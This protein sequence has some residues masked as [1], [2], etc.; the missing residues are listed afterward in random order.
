MKK[1][2]LLPEEISRKIAAGEVIERPRSVVKEL[3]ENSLD[4][5]ASEIKVEL[6]D[7]GKKL[8][9]VTDNGLGMSRKDTL[10]C[11][12]RHS[13]S[14]ISLE[15]DLEEIS[16][17]GF[18]G[19]ALPSISSVS[20]VVLKTA[21]PDDKV[22]ICI[23]REGE[24]VLE[25]IDIA[26]PGGTC[27]EVRDLFFNLPA[28]RKFLRSDRSE[29]SHVVRY[30]TETSLAFPQVGFSLIHGKRQVFSYPAVKSLKERIF[31]IYGRNVLE[32]L[33]AVE[34]SDNGRNITGFLS[35]PPSGRR[36]RG[37][38]F[39]FINS[40]PVRD[41]SLQAALNQAY[42]GFLEKDLSPA[43]F[44]FLKIPYEEVDINVHPAKT[45]VRF[46][47]PQVLFQ[48]VF[49]VAR[50]AVLRETGVKEVYVSGPEERPSARIEERSFQSSFEW[51][52]KGVPGKQGAIHSRTYYQE[53]P[54]DSQ[55]PRV[56]G[57]FMQTYIVAEAEDGLMIID[58]HNAH[59][60]VLFERY[61]TIDKDKAWP[62]SAALLSAV[63]EL[64]PSQSV[65][66]EDRE[67]ALQELGF[68]VEH[69]GERSYAL[70]EYPDIFSEKTAREVLFAMLEEPKDDKLED[71]RDR[72]LATMACK[73]AVKAGEM[74]AYDKMTYL[75]D[76]LFKTENPTLCPHGRP[77]IVRMTATEIEKGLKRK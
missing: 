35:R 64:S 75:V 8:I 45:E 23:K 21:E 67:A 46:K 16:T 5:G 34:T 36:N 49:N 42:K 39:F 26:F 60:R 57:Q 55:F 50:Q 11:F 2:I 59:E 71:V 30:M 27:V 37:L 40:R 43:G 54:G 74:L 24:K 53:K 44:I 73:S 69:M 7:G 61:K 33:T 56:L 62:R 65:S 13:T 32:G 72:M 41:R 29:L 48:L 52:E 9:R 20:R 17:L 18:R 12:E 68:R 3:V 22:G 70:K 28:R 25:V 10:L 38:Q 1:I 77:V 4:A 58:Q 15:S 19:E 47:D 51:K 63:F 6:E 31:Q 66:F 76:K 14:K